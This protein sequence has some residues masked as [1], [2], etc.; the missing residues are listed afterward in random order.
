MGEIAFQRR[1]RPWAVS[2]T[3]SPGRNGESP[4]GGRAAWR[5]HPFVQRAHSLFV[6][7][8]RSLRALALSHTL[9]HR[10][11]EEQDRPVSLL[12]RLVQVRPGHRGVFRVL[13]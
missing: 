9:G 6:D 4:M 3:G 2:A 13:R 1:T 5:L 12:K 10:L 11:S 7:T 8:I